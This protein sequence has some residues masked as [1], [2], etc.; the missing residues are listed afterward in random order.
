[1]P[2]ACGRSATSRENARAPARG[3]AAHTEPFVL[4]TP[5]FDNENEVRNG[6]GIDRI[7]R[8]IQQDQVRILKHGARKKRALHLP[9]GQAVEGA[10]LKTGQSN[11]VK[12]SGKPDLV[13]GREAPK[14]AALLPVTEG[15]EIDHTRRKRPVEF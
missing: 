5:G 3:R 11:R 6:A 7:E 12:A 13:G 15:H 14:Q 9:A 1:M 2:P 8:L 10:L 4:R